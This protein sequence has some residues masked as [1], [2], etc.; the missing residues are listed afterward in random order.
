M[1]ANEQTEAALKDQMV[2]DLRSVNDNAPYLWHIGMWHVQIV[3]KL[4]D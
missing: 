1:F 4:N 2:G 3:S